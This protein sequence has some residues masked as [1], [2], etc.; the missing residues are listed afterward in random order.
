MRRDAALVGADRGRV[1]CAL[2]VLVLRVQ[3]KD[4]IRL[5]RGSIMTVKKNKKTKPASD[6]VRY[7]A[8]RTE[9]EELARQLGDHPTG[10]TF[11]E[12]L[13]SSNQQEFELWLPKNFIRS[14]S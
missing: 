7:V 5:L 1:A 10:V 14:P 9:V 2:R 12:M 4:Y 6:Q 8:T 13:T 3:A 11:R